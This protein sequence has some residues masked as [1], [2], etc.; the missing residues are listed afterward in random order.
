MK[1]K[2]KT[3]IVM[4]LWFAEI[5]AREIVNEVNNVYHTE[6]EYQSPRDKNRTITVDLDLMGV[7]MQIDPNGWWGG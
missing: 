4:A 1:T 2:K 5:R 7:A 3:D 6:N